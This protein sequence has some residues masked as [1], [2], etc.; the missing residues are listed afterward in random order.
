MI[1]VVL[2]VVAIILGYYL[3]Q[4]RFTY[5]SSRGFKQLEPQFFFGDGKELITLKSSFGVFLKDLYFKHKKSGILGIYVSYIP[6]VLITD[7]NLAQDILIRDFNSFHDRPMPCDEKVDP[8]SGSLFNVGGQKWKDL[9]VKLTPTFTSGK[10]KGMFP[11][12]KN[13]GQVLEDYLLRNMKNGVDVFEF[14]DLM[15]RY[16]TNIISSVAFGIDNDSI[17][18]PDHIFRRMGAKIFETK[19]M[20]GIKSMMNLA[21]PKLMHKLRVKML[22]NDVNEFIFSIVKQTVDYREKN[23]VSRND[24][25]QMLIQLKNQGFVS[26][27]KGVKNDKQPENSSEKIS[28]IDFNTLAAQ[29]FVFFAAG[30]KW[31]IDIVAIEI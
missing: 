11:I 30:K 5:W 6:Q 26:V 18:E 27:D 21:S 8:L 2:F 17:N 7:P 29:V 23:N 9:R 10:L 12:I 22:D 19:F 14:R 24:F 31:L 25:L 1:L 28:K 13:V 4:H 3:N 15:A 20:N 16:N